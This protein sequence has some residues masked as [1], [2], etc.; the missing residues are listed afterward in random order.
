MNVEL[1]DF[2]GYTIRFEDVTSSR[3]KIKY[4]TDGMLLRELLG[5]P[6]LSQYSCI[7]LDEAHERTLRTDILFGMMKRIQ[8]VRK[9]LKIIIMSATLDAE[10]FAQFF[11]AE[12]IYVAGRQYPVEV[13]HA[14]SQQEDHLDS[15]L[16]ATFQIHMERPQGDI[17]VFLTG[18]EEIEGL[19]K[20][21][22]DHAAD[23]PPEK[24]KLLVCPIFASLP[25]AQQSQVFEPAPPGV[26]KVILATN[27]AETSITIEGIK[28]IV[29]TG[30]VKQR[31]FHAR[32]GA[33]LETL[34]VKPISKA[35]SKQRAGRAGRQAQCYRL[36]TKQAFLR[37]DNDIVPEILRCNL[38]S[39][40]L[41]MKAAGITDV[42]NFDYLDRP[43]RDAMLSALERLYALH[44]LDNHG[45]LT[46]LGRKIAE[47]PLD[48]PFAKVLIMSQEYKCTKEMLTIVAMLSVEN[49][50][51]VPVDK[52][53][54]AAEARNKFINHQGDHLTLL[55]IWKAYLDV[56]KDRDWC[57]DNFIN[58]RSL[59]Q[60]VRGQLQTFCDRL[61]IPTGTSCLK[62]GIQIG[63]TEPILRCLLTGF[64]T[65]TGVLQ[66]DG[67]Y[68]SVATSQVM[69]IHPSS[70]LF[71]KKANAIFYHEMVK[72]TRNYVRSVS[73]V[74]AGWIM[75]A[76][77]NYFGWISFGE[78]GR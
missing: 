70:V 21:I 13:Y 77:P 57:N 45:E 60:K 35:S 44:A 48:P 55:N 72:T 61:G 42:V 53:E 12:V 51:F 23:L 75:E 19:E 32:N 39:A 37:M 27:I 68:K 33:G 40:L 29:D 76:A 66:Q 4:M 67:T 54:Q 11:G 69:H 46:D 28:Y 64:F 24:M 71:R 30:M 36:Y 78:V 1:G 9:D 2:V 63:D 34:N 73:S 25:T 14:Q 15:A 59:K 3:T 43:S 18:Q 16:V 49:I 7:I 31:E 26:R 58:A 56:G 41:Q 5:D 38:G 47:F 74:E 22:N 8:R 52:R 6:N 10:R 17:L 65:N 50:T 62:E 20:L